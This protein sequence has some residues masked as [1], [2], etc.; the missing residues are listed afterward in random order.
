MCPFRYVAINLGVLIRM[1]NSQTLYIDLVNN[2][3]M[4]NVVGLTL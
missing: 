3:Y 2:L 4:V 1:K